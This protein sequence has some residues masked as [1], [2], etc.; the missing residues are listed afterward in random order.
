MNLGI[1]ERNA[2]VTGG[3][4]GIGLAICNSLLSEGCNVATFA[5]GQTSDFSEVDPAILCLRADVFDPFS[6]D[7]FINNILDKFKHV[8]ILVNCVGGGGRWGIDPISTPYHVWEEVYT[9]NLYAMIVLTQAVLPKM[10]ERKWGRIVTVSSI[11]GREG[12]GKPWFNM[13]KSSQISAMKCLA[14]YPTYA[15]SNITFNSVAPGSVNTGGWYDLA[16][17]DPDT[18]FAE[19]DKRPLGRLGTSEEIADVVTFLCSKRASLINGA[20]IAI[21]GGEGRSF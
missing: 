14:L 12:G 9:K 21:D 16:A 1:T 2:I 7:D 13:A 5:R 4:A 6:I 19:C 11:Y 3:T 20:C 10:V 18:Y 8:D 15:R 17:R